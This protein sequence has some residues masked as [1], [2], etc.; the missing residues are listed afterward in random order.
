[1]DSIPLRKVFVSSTTKDLWQYRQVA[2]QLIEDINKDYIGEFQL[3]TI[4]M[5]TKALSGERKTAKDV[6]KSWVNECDWFVLIVAWNYGYI[7]EGD[8]Y[9]VTEWEYREATSDTNKKLCFIFLAGEQ[10]DGEKAYRAL[11]RSTEKENLTDWKAINLDEADYEQALIEFDNTGKS[12]FLAI[13]K[14]KSELRK[15]EFKIFT[16]I[17]DFKSLLRLALKSRIKQAL[18]SEG[19]SDGFTTELYKF[20]EHI[21]N[22]LK[23]VELLAT[24]KRIHDGLHVIRQFGIRRWREEVIMQWNQVELPQPAQFTYLSGL[25]QIK[26]ARSVLIGYI[27]NLPD[28]DELNT[29]KTAVNMVLETKF[30]NQPLDKSQFEELTDLFA[31][32]VQ[33]AFIYAN[34]AMLMKGSNMK[35]CRPANQAN[36]GH[37]EHITF[38]TEIEQTL[39]AGHSALKTLFLQHNEWQGLHDQMER[40]DST[41]GIPKMF[42]YELAGLIDNPGKIKES[43]QYAREVAKVSE[44]QDDWHKKIQALDSSFEQLLTEKSEPAYESLR[45]AFDDLFFEIDRDT[46]KK[47]ENATKCALKNS[48]AIE[49]KINEI[50][51]K[52]N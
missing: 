10:S 46:L 38:L 19:A 49:S 44:N 9:S 1:M 27:N 51:T 6:S 33:T 47:V 2:E 48:E 50:A 12:K 43:L 17:E 30:E 52:A 31:R 18:K 36:L 4:S 8:I 14:F 5:D 34:G 20:N 11:D 24:L 13:E 23:Q 7:P 21:N 29:L 28:Q 15:K 3:Q 39:N 40:I 42:F 32:R 26:E 16:D 45:K 25:M 35:V 37:Q 41:K 22:C